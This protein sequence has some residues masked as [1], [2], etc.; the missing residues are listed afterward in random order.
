MQAR[1]WAV[2]SGVLQYANDISGCDRVTGSYR[3]SDGK[4]GRTQ[5]IVVNDRDDATTG[6]DA[7]VLNTPRARRMNLLSRLSGQIRSAVTGQPPLRRW[8]EAPEHFSSTGQRPLPGWRRAAP[9]GGGGPASG[10]A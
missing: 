8:I 2:A 10:V 7:H 1:H 3:G 9:P 4:I 5:P 6:D